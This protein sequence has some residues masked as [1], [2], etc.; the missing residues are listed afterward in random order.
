MAD[1]LVRGGTSEIAEASPVSEEAS[2]ASEEAWAAARA[3]NR[4]GEEAAKVVAGLLDRSIG[5]MALC[6]EA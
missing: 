6:L 1:I 4:E 3:P 2:P 5:W